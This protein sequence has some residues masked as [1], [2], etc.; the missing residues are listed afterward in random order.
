[1]GPYGDLEGLATFCVIIYTCCI[2]VLFHIA[3]GA[4][5]FQKTSLCKYYITVKRVSALQWASDCSVKLPCF[6]FV[7]WHEL[8]NVLGGCTGRLAALGRL[9]VDQPCACALRLDSDTRCMPC[10]T[11]HVCLLCH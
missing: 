7:L 11:V 2:V 5:V 6:H 3:C 4:S 8:V 9:G 10:S 1:M